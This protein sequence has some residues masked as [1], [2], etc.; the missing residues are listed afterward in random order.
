MAITKVWLD[1]NEGVVCSECQAIREQEHVDAMT[2]TT[3]Y[4]T[5]IEEAANAKPDA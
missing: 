3:T 2:K 5:T 4:K 1:E